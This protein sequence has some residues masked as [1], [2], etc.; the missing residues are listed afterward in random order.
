MKRWILLCIVFI[1]SAQYISIKSLMTIKTL[2]TFTAQTIDDNQASQDIMANGG[3]AL[4]FRSTC[5][6]CLLEY[7][8]WI[9]M[10]AQFPKVPFVM[11]LHKQS[12]E[13]IKHFFTRHENPFDYVITDDHNVLWE[14]FGARSTPEAFIFNHQSKLIGHQGYMRSGTAVLEERLRLLNQIIIQQEQKERV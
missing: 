4:F 1:S 14:K 12:A 5:G 3:V 11:I 2:P 6:Y 9:E 13:S 10:K 8:K 7:P